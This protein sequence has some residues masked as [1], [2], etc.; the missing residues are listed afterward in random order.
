MDKYSLSLIDLSD[1]LGISRQA[2][3]QMAAKREDIGASVLKNKKQNT[4]LHPGTV[5]DI[6]TSRGY[7]YL[8][9]SIAFQVI[10]GGVGKTTLAKNF[11]VRAAQ[12]G[13]KVLM[14]SKIVEYQQRKPRLVFFHL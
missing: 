7:K 13:Y 1:L 3:S 10:K 12:Y 8:K 9:K 14:Y 4:H 2:M 5:R 11:G 6:L